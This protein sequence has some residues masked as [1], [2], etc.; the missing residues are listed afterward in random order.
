MERSIAAKYAARPAARFVRP[1]LRDRQRRL[2]L[3][4]TA[5]FRAAPLRPTVLQQSP[6][7]TLTRLR[8]G[9]RSFRASRPA[10]LTDGRP[11]PAIEIHWARSGRSADRRPGAATAPWLG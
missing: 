3:R 5:T 10:R 1:S 9:W 7:S 4:A 2:G 11:R 8:G 6:T